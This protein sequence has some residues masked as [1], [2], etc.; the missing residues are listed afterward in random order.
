MANAEQSPIPA[1]PSDV[2][3]IDFVNSAFTHHLGTDA[4]GDRIASDTWQAWF[5]DRY[6][7]TPK[8]RGA[9]PLDELVRLR[10][11][12]RRILERWAAGLAPTQRDVRLLDARISA[13]PTRP[14][15]AGTGPSLE[16][17]YEPLRWDWAWV[18]ASVTTSAVEL[19]STGD[20]NRLKTCDNPSCSWLF[21][22]ATVNRSRRFCS[23]TPCATLIRVRRFRQPG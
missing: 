9:A 13:A 19:M 3:C 10:R 21:Y 22:D 15:V 6:G 7:L 11:K 12:L 1:N 20:P 8:P 17:A 2:A 4:T 18:M 5:L 16:L 23:T 14:R